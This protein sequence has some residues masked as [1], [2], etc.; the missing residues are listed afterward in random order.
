MKKKRVKNIILILL[1]CTIFQFTCTAYS[2]WFGEINYDAEYNKGTN[3][4]LGKWFFEYENSNQSYSLDE[5]FFLD[6]NITD[7]IIPKDTVVYFKNKEGVTTKFVAII[8]GGVDLS[9]PKNRL[10]ND[11]NT[12]IFYKMKYAE[13][14][15]EY[16][17]SHQYYRYDLVT[18]NGRI[19]EYIW[20]ITHNPNTSSAVAPTNKR[21]WKD[22]TDEIN[23]MGLSL[24]K[25][26]F[27][28]C[29]YEEG[30]IVMSN[31]NRRTS[32]PLYYKSKKSYYANYAPNNSPNYWEA[33]N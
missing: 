5:Q 3:I 20:G 2:V 7:D 19:Y 17:A 1:I 16:R 12:S 10:P 27:R 6:G 31:Y 24:D 26:W 25:L 15:S 9:D 23:K 18:Y 11:L 33:R 13:V 22:V 21:R 29:L 32:G 8:D 28:Y 30:D 14:T 4:A